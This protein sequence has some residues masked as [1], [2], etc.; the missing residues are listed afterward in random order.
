MSNWDL[1]RSLAAAQN[2]VLLLRK[3]SD[4]MI[5]VMPSALLELY[6]INRIASARGYKTEE[7]KYL[8]EEALKLSSMMG[9][10]FVKIFHQIVSKRYY[11][12]KYPVEVKIF[13]HHTVR[14]SL[15]LSLSS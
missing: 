3:I 7:M 8:K 12:Y 1:K 11:F 15:G 4:Q 6:E 13:V 5:T 2:K 14:S 9:D 10:S